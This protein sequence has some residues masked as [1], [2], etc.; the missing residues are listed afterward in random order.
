M[1]AGRTGSDTAGAPGRQEFPVLGVEVA[2]GVT[3][4]GAQN[5]CR[6][7]RPPHAGGTG[8]GRRRCRAAAGRADRGGH[9]ARCGRRCG[10][11]RPGPESDAGAGPGV[12][13]PPPRASTSAAQRRTV[14]PPCASRIG[15]ACGRPRRHRRQRAGTRPRDRPAPTSTSSA[16]WA[17]RSSAACRWG[18][19]DSRLGRSSAGSSPR[20]SR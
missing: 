1:V 10:D 3:W 14:P 9:A 20:A 16:R 19:P 6:H 5:A 15:P 13:P 4:E 8:A 17:N 2:F 11:G 7:P 18:R 12:R